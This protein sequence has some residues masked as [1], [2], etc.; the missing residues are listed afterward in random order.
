MVTGFVLLRM[1]NKFSL[2]QPPLVEKFTLVVDDINVTGNWGRTTD[3]DKIEYNFATI[4]KDLTETMQSHAVMAMGRATIV[5]S[6]GRFVTVTE[7][8][9]DRS[10]SSMTFFDFNMAVQAGK[11]RNKL[12][13][14][15]SDNIMNEWF[16]VRK[17][18]SHH[19]TAN[20]D[21]VKLTLYAE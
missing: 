20:D 13:D 8:N 10:V 11:L 16:A 1:E 7:V 17:V 12:F 3:I 9:K 21:N 5:S 18:L 6:M 15:Y 14:G 19:F 2:L 4:G